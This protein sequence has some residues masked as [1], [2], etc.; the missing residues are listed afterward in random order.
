MKILI[1]KW[2]IQSITSTSRRIYIKMSKSNS[3]FVKESYN[4]RGIS[5]SFGWRLP[6]KFK[7]TATIKDPDNRF[8]LGS[9]MI[10]TE[11]DS[12]GEHT[13]TTVEARHFFCS[14]NLLRI[15]CAT[16]VLKPCNG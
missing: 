15:N 2:L 13:R 7:A 12:S 10:A 8:E 3:T 11:N 9:R 5:C 6:K 14:T 16:N 4:S 1:F